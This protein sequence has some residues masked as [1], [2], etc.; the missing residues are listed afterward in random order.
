MRIAIA[1]HWFTLDFTSGSDHDG[2][3]DLGCAVL[4]LA[5]P[6]TISLRLPEGDD[7]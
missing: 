4:D 3:P 5:E 7:R 2:H 1:C 6:H